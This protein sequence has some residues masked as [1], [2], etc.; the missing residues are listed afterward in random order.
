MFIVVARPFS[1]VGTNRIVAAYLVLAV[2]DSI[3]H[4]IPAEKSYV[5]MFL[6]F[7]SGNNNN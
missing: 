6:D 4:F 5:R 1:Y 3:F 2:S 7:L